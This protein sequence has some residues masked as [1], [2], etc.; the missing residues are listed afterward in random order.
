MCIITVQGSYRQVFQDLL[1]GF[2][3]IFK[4]KFMKNTDSY[5]KFLLQKYK[6]EENGEISTKN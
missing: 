6:I 3:M 4:D 5:V 1:K 2:P